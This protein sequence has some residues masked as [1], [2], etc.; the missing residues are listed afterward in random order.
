MPAG[1]QED[2]AHELHH[3]HCHPVSTRIVVSRVL[4]ARPPR[5]PTLSPKEV[6]SFGVTEPEAQLDWDIDAARGLIAARPRTAQRLEQNWLES[7]LG[8][9]THHHT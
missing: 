7:W 1:I 6:Y 2:H 4:F 8:E 5:R 3:R 9:R